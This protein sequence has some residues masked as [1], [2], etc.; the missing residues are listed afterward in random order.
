MSCAVWPVFFDISVLDMVCLWREVSLPSFLRNKNLW[1]TSFKIDDN[2]AITLPLQVS[3]TLTNPPRNSQPVP[4]GEP[5]PNCSF[6]A[7]LRQYAVAWAESL[8]GLISGHQSWAVFCRYRCR[9]L[10]AES[11]KGSD[12]NAELKQRLQL[13]ETG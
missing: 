10:L 12:R 3:P 13:W 7:P 2:L 9:L 6:E 11:A 8:E 5:L 4:P 1:V